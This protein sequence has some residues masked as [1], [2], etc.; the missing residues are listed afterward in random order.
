MPDVDEYRRQRK[1]VVKIFFN[2]AH[3]IS[4]DTLLPTIETQP[5]NAVTTFYVI[6]KGSDFT[7]ATFVPQSSVHSFPHMDRNN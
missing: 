7:T 5:Q 6:N 1:K 3:L 4:L 2:P